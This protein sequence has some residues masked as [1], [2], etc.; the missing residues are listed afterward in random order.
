MRGK[1]VPQHV[2][3]KRRTQAGLSPVGRKYLPHAYAAERGAT[4]V[5]EERGRQ[6]LFA[7]AN[8]LGARIAQIALH[9]C[10]G[11][12]ADRDNALLVAL[13]DASDAANCSIEI[14]DAKG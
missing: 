13:A 12:L 9:Q 2:R 10:E 1:T 14:H 11:L 8:Q 3:R 5:N 4:P 6:G 7:L